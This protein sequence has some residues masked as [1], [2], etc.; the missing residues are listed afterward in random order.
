MIGDIIQ[1]KNYSPKPKNP[2]IAMVFREIGLADERGTVQFEY[3]KK[4]KIII[5]SII[6][7]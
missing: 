4:Y 7:S 6:Q 2:K 1:E 3:I 5:F